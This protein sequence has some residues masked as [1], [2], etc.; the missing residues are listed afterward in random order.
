MEL[1]GIGV[2]AGSVRGAIEV[3]NNS[4]HDCHLYGY[5]DLE[6]LDAVYRSLPSHIS[7]S[8]TA[9]FEPTPAVAD[10]VLLPF[11]TPKID[12]GHP[13]QGHAYIP[14]GWTGMG[15]PC[16]A[17]VRLRVTP[18]GSRSSTVITVGDPA[19]AGYIS[20]CSGGAV[21]VLPVRATP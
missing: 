20:M 12:P 7:P 2:A 21:T 17:V 9:F 14:L 4:S 10:V 8:I 19:G 5:A 11:G 13:V 3:R 18:P 15:E 16:A 1:I 6:L